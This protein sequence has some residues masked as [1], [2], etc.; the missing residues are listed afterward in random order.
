MEPS[1]TLADRMWDHLSVREPPYLKGPPEVPLMHFPPTAP[2]LCV[3]DLERSWVTLRLKS[4][5]GRSRTQC[6]W[7]LKIVAAF[8]NCL[9]ASGRLEMAVSQVNLQA[10]AGIRIR[11][12]TGTSLNFWL[13]QV[14]G[15]AYAANHEISRT[16][17]DRNLPCVC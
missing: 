2:L 16:T 9:P 5:L 14:D 8:L 13:D 1:Q 15:T 7:R 4:L 11:G 6:H 17:N 3:Y 10:V 12:L